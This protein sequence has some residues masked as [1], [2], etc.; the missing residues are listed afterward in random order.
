VVK[1]FKPRADGRFDVR[2]PAPAGGQAAAYRLSTRVRK[3]DKAPKL[4]PTFTL[5][6]YVDLGQASATS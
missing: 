6:R 2:V 5:P 4:Y 1:R 3:L